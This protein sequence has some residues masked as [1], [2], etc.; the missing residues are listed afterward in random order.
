MKFRFFLCQLSRKNKKKHFA[1]RFTLYLKLKNF[2][3]QR[4]EKKLEEIKVNSI[5]NLVNDDEDTTK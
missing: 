3:P 4:Q 1:F 2:G 5:I